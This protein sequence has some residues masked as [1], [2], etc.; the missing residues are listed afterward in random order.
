MHAAACGLWPVVLGLACTAGLASGQSFRGIGTHPQGRE[1]YAAGVSG[2]GSVVV[3]AQYDPLGGSHGLGGLVAIRWTAGGGR[4]PLGLLDGGDSSFAYGA[5]LDGSVIAGRACAATCATVQPFRWTDPGPIQGLGW[6]PGSSYG[7]AQGIS[8]DGTTIVGFGVNDSSFEVYPTMWREE[9]G[10]VALDRL[11]GGGAAYVQGASANG[12]TLA[13]RA[14]DAD[15]HQQ[16]ALWA[17]DGS[18]T[19]L[20]FLTDPGPLPYSMARAITPT[21]SVVVGIAHGADGMGGYTYQGF[22]WTQAGGMQGLGVSGPHGNLL[23]TAAMDVSASGRIVV[24]A[25]GGVMGWGDGSQAAVW[26]EGEGWRDLA[27]LLIDDYGLDQ[28]GD[29]VLVEALGVSN[30]GS[31]IVGWGFNPGGFEEG[32]VATLVP[33]CPGD[34]NGDGAANTLDVLAFLNAWAAGDPAADFNGDG[35]VNTLDVLAFLNAWAGGC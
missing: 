32:F 22:R 5:S 2:D 4:V 30:D 24:G 18:I 23:T 15:H 8:D 27:T 17:G 1:S 35:A 25:W 3:G 11:P 19:P 6:I 9:L 26:R 31:V 7:L 34:F 16:A 14:W 28:V 21:G 12:S 10:V 29:W 33:D 13:G 20:G